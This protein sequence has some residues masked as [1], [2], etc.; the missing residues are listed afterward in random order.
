M[1][2]TVIIEDSADSDLRRCHE[3]G[4]RN[5]GKKQAE[6]WFREMI[7]EMRTLQAFPERCPIAPDT[8]QFTEEIR[9]LIVGRYRVLFT[10]KRTTVHILHVRGAYPGERIEAPDEP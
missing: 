3:W 10:I 9:H 2:Y 1:K 7:R 4:V 5:W 8:E 6:K